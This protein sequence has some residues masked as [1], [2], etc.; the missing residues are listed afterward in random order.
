V[1][2]RTPEF[3]CEKFHKRVLLKA[4]SSNGPSTTRYAGI[5]LQ[6][7]VSILVFLYVG[8]WLDRKFGT[9]PIFLML[10]VFVGAGAA[11]YS[12]YRKL[13]ADQN[14]EDEDHRQ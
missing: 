10:G 11:F 8:Q 9:S 5:G 3:A 4:V 1:G 13:M 12:M 7:A 6:F 2:V 14:A